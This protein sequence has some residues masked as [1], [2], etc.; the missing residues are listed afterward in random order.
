LSACQNLM[1]IKDS[2][3]KAVR[4][5][6]FTAFLDAEEIPHK[7][8]GREAVTIC[9]WHNDT[10][11]SL[12]VNDDQG[13]CFCFVCRGAGDIIS[14][15][16]ERFGLSFSDA[17]ERIASRHNITVEFD[18]IDPETARREAAAKHAQ[19]S[20][21]QRQQEIFRSD[22]K[23]PRAARIRNIIKARG[24]A[25]ETAKEFG[26]G[27]C[28]H[29]FFG[30][31]ITVPIEDHRGDLI[32]FTARATDD[33]TKPKYKNSAQSDIFD[34]S[35]IVY[36]EYKASKFIKDSD[37][38]IFV[39][40]HFD[41]ISL[42]QHGIKN[43]VAL[44]GTG[45]PSHSVISRLLRKTK[46]FIVCYDGDEGGK[47]GI[48]HFIKSAGPIACKGGLTLSI[49]KLPVGMDPD[50]MVRSDLDGFYA[51]I[52]SATSWL[53]W[54][55]DEWLIN[56]DKTDTARFSAVEIA[57]KQLVDSI[58]SPALR[59]Y[60]IDKTC[61]ALADDAKSAAKIA[62]DWHSTL[63]S[64][65]VLRTWNPPDPA[66]TRMA[67]ERRLLRL[68]VHHPDI[69]GHCRPLMNLIESPAYRWMW[70]R[71]AELEDFGQGILDPYS[72]MAILSVCEPYH[73]RQLRS[74][75]MPTIKVHCNHDIISHI[76]HVL[77][78]K[79]VITDQ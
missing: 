55:I 18:N 61:K 13:F 49:A 34:K 43:V 23:D 71:L 62:Q 73:T 70:Q 5:L 32:G 40:G 31:R 30:G 16:R 51:C 14:Y 76:E 2:T 53:D 25:P 67:A 54:Q 36:N 50:T 37:Y 60:Y 7:R 19:I 52:E 41:V 77:Q 79:L 10:N 26:L 6:P 24:L 66:W 17:V 45:S 69:R 29:G 15:A 42:W 56:L 20:E 9:P 39:E 12:T 47:N 78:Q 4:D 22:L 8:I 72:V 64:I 57:I 28:R 21:L 33:E 11:P 44:Q 46:R 63:S 68:Y 59:Q 65:P 38:V 48:E 35:S 3:I 74:L 1:G 58:Q 75:A 27:Y